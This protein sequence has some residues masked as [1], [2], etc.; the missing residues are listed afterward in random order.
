M[1]PFKTVASLCL[2]EK[3]VVV[4]DDDDDDDDDGGHFK[5]SDYCIT[6]CT[7]S[8]K[9]VG[10]AATLSWTHTSMGRSIPSLGDSLVFL[11]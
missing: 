4:V 5:A 7:L 1:E 9:R 10:R 11:D 8:V 6:Q 2:R 3:V